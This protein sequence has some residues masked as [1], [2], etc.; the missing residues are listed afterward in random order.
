MLGLIIE[1]CEFRPSGFLLPW[2]R[3]C[4]VSLFPTHPRII[5]KFCCFLIGR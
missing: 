5:S 3:P 2:S 1:R 4:L